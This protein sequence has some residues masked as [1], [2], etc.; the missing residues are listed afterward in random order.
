M[1][2]YKVSIVIPLYNKE[3]SIKDTI[4]SCTSQTYNNIEIIVVDDGSTDNSPAIVKLIAD[5]RVI[6]KWKKNEGVSCARNYGVKVSTGDWIL[7]LDAD[8]RLYPDAIEQLMLPILKDNTIDISCANL[9]TE[10][11]GKLFL[12]NSNYDVGYVK[13]NYKEYYKRRIYY[14]TGNNI[15]R[16]SLVLEHPFD[17]HLKRF[18]DLKNTLE[19]LARAKMYSSAKPV[20]VYEK[21]YSELSNTSIPLE[22][23]YTGNVIFHNLPFWG[24]MI[25]S[26]LILEEMRGAYKDKTWFLIKKYKWNLLYATPTFFTRL[27]NKFFRNI[28][29]ND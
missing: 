29:Q 2:N 7:F 23:S 13:D 9:H 20:M 5:D 27:K 21:A 28:G 25:V 1:V 12:F 17:T 8:D 22:Q 10:Y 14:R 11:K 18:E 4:K 24:K 19:M 26:K 16:R 6:Y 15:T 3:Q